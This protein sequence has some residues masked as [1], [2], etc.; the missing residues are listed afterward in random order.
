V[1]WKPI[2]TMPEG[3]TAL[4]KIDDEDGCRNDQRLTK[5][6]RIPGQTRPLFFAGDMYVYYT[7][8]H[9]KDES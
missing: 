9:W 2:D 8:T 5:K 3:L 4:T 6:T 7:P 1:S